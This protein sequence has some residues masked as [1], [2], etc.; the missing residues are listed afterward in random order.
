MGKFSFSKKIKLAVIGTGT[1]IGAAT[2]FTHSEPGLR[3]HGVV[4]GAAKG[5]LGGSALAFAPELARFAGRTAKTE[6][7][8]LVKGAKSIRGK[9]LRLKTK[10]KVIFRR[11]R[12]K[13][14]PIRINQ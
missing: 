10:G 12:G 11:I 8:D 14:R 3:K 2:G 9:G 7:K 4:E 1:T 6:I 5:F 13:L